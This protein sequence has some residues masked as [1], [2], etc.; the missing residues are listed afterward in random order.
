MKLFLDQDIL[1][2]QASNLD[3][4]RTS[5]GLEISSSLGRGFIDAIEHTKGLSFYYFEYQFEQPYT[6]ETYNREESCVY[7]LMVNLS[8]QAMDKVVGDQGVRIHKYEPTGM[9]AYPP[10]S[11]VMSTS[12]P[13]KVYQM[14]VIKM[15]RDLLVEYFGEDNAIFSHL[16][17][18]VFEDLDYQSE[19]L[20]RC[21]LSPQS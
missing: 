4:N 11:M 21:I 20:I 18:M 8:T 1:D 17:S 3:G 7:A 10:G 6:Q 2:Q 16:N 15:S 14:A 12:Q 19:V 5:T 13:G 9:I